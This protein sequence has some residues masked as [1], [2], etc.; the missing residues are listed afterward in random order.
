MHSTD[1]RQKMISLR[2]SQVEYEVFKAQYRA[3]G[4]RNMS[5]LARLALQRLVTESQGSRRGFCGQV[6]Q[7]GQTAPTRRV[8]G[9][10]ACRA[11]EGIVMRMSNR[12]RQKPATACAL[13]MLALAC[14]SAQ[15]PPANNAPPLLAMSS[16][17]TIRS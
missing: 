14:A 17:P 15:Q 16:A 2:L 7:V 12:M 8:P 3:A 4:A 5:E 9:P 10:A 11:G 1:S 6:V 13:A